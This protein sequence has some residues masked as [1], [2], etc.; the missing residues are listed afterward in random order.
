M[1]YSAL[2]CYESEFTLCDMIGGV[3]TNGNR[4][5]PVARIAFDALMSSG[6]STTIYP[7]S[8]REL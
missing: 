5:A 4:M 7:C 6:A 8:A 2:Y 1:T 3:V